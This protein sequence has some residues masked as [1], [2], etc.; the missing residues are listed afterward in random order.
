MSVQ[1]RANA[2]FSEMVEEIQSESPGVLLSKTEKKVLKSLSKR[3]SAFEKADLR[4]TETLE[5][6]QKEAAQRRSEASE[7]ICELCNNEIEIGQSYIGVMGKHVLHLECYN[8]G[9]KSTVSELVKS[10]LF[11]REAKRFSKTVELEPEQKIDVEKTCFWCKKEIKDNEEHFVRK[12]NR[13]IHVENCYDAWFADTVKPKPTIEPSQRPENT[14]IWCGKEI[15]RLAALISVHDGRERLSFHI[16]CYN[17]YLEDSQKKALDK[18]E[19]A[20]DVDYL[21]CRRCGKTIQEG[22]HA[23]VSANGSFHSKCYLNTSKN[24]KEREK[25]ESVKKTPR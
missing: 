3:L 15:H 14:C 12:D 5:R 25:N 8:K 17:E 16:D 24:S 11:K 9:I 1:T 21:V 13:P 19:D 18:L 20:P 23:S 10:P 22:E 4:V 7:Q 2:L 6:L